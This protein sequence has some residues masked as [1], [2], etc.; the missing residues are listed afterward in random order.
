MPDEFTPYEHGMERLLEQIAA[1]S[2]Q[3]ALADVQLLQ[4]RL[5]KNIARMRRYSRNNPITEAEQNEILDRLNEI[6][7][8][9]TNKSFNEWCKIN[10]DSPLPQLFPSL[11]SAA[12]SPSLTI[13]FIVQTYIRDVSRSLQKTLSLFEDGERIYPFQCE[14]AHRALQQCNASLSPETIDL[15]APTDTSQTSLVVALLHIQHN[16]EEIIGLI[17]EFENLCQKRSGQKQREHIHKKLNNTIDYMRQ[18]HL[19]SLYIA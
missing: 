17:G 12:H 3:Q 10:H 19:I 11:S 5:K 1:S 8:R 2:D 13:P 4:A 6:S 16:V 7:M 18:H 9:T 14:H 15:I